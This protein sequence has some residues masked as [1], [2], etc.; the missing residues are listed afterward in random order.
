MATVEAWLQTGFSGDDQGQLARC[1]LQ[2]DKLRR[3][4]LGKGITYNVWRDAQAANAW[5]HPFAVLPYLLTGGQEC[6]G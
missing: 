5:L 1:V 4:L 6:Q 2:M 3:V